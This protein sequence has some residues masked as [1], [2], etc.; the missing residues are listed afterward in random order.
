M[1]QCCVGCGNE[2]SSDF[3]VPEGASSR[4]SR[5]V[6]PTEVGNSDWEC[7][8]VPVFVCHHQGVFSELT[9]GPDLTSGLVFISHINYG[10]MFACVGQRRC[11]FCPSFRLHASLD[12]VVGFFPQMKNCKMLQ[13]FRVCC[14]WCW[15]ILLLHNELQTGT[16]LDG[17]ENELET[18]D[19]FRSV[20]IKMF[21][22]NVWKFIFLLQN[23]I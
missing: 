1:R 4:F 16:Q 23:L 17:Y 20:L 6:P 5:V 21:C 14:I 11:K 15:W 13:N 2:S 18:G 3:V 12:Q 9:H 7:E 22:W 19:V 8:C 10:G